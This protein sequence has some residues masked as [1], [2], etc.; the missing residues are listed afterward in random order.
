MR[1]MQ[2]R[3]VKKLT[4]DYTPNNGVVIELRQSGCRTCS[5]N[6]YVLLSLLKKLLNTL[7]R[8]LCLKME[9]FESKQSLLVGQDCIHT[10]THTHTH[11]HKSIA[12]ILGKKMGAIP[13]RK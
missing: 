12:E 8:A 3:E 1:K 4:P 13:S 10:H 5:L 2:Y 9:K 11:T 7:H 6:L